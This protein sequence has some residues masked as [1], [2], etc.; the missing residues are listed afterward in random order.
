MMLEVVV[1]VIIIITM[2][3]TVKEFTLGTPM[4]LGHSDPQQTELVSHKV[5][6]VVFSLFFHPSLC[7]K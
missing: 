7:G 1:V 5:V 4:S 3:K 6:N 2:M